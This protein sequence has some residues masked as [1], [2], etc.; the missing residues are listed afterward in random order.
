MSIQSIDARNPFRGGGGELVS[1]SVAAGIGVSMPW[2][3]AAVQGGGRAGR[4]W[5]SHAGT[6]IIARRPSAE[7]RRER[8]RP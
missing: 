5:A 6:A 3:G 1:G 4:E 2:G 8:G 7:D